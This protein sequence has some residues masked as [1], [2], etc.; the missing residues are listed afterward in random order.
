MG[1]G[2]SE[3]QGGSVDDEVV[4]VERVEDGTQTG[5]RPAF[6][7]RSNWLKIRNVLGLCTAAARDL[8]LLPK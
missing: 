6:R 5:G 8:L 1:R 4:L 3:Q 2:E 7:R